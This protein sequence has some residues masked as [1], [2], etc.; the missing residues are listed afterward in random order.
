[1]NRTLEELA[2][3]LF[4]SWFIDFDGHDDLVDSEIGPV[5]RGWEVGRDPEAQ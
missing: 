2:Q 5:P 4:K 1:M 3:A